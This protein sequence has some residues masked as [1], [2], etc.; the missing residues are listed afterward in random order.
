MTTLCLTRAHIL[1]IAGYAR[2]HDRARIGRDLHLAPGT[3][4]QRLRRAARSV[5]IH[6]GDLAPQLVHYAYQHGYLDGLRPERRWP[7]GVLPPRQAATLD[8]I[9]RGLSL[10]ETAAEMGLSAHTVA[11]HRQSLY[12]LLGARTTAHAVARAWQ[13][14]LFE[15]G[16]S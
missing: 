6:A 11:T 4:A 8:A 12:A 13:L 9:T 15:G 1:V 16:P 14:G 10:D 5:G 7:V 3:V 2:G